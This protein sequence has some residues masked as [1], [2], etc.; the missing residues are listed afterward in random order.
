M[1]KT[2]LL[3]II[4]FTL[5]SSNNILSML[6]RGHHVT[7]F[8]THI[9][10]KARPFHTRNGTD[11]FELPSTNVFTPFGQYLYKNNPELV[12]DLY[13]RNNTLI[14]REREKMAILSSRINLLE[15]QNDLAIDHLFHHGP[16]N[17]L[18]LTALEK[19][20]QNSLA[21]E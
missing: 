6:K 1:K 11:H 14:K 17:L 15:A 8:R 7:S 16:L 10:Q 9:F 4:V 2:T 19:K 13:N 3:S 18:Q 21:K 20:L 5:A 12:Q